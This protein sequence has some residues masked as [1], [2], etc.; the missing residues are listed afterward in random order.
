MQACGTSLVSQSTV[1]ASLSAFL[2][3][4]LGARSMM[5]RTVCYRMP[6]A[7]LLGFESKPRLVADRPEIRTMTTSRLMVDLFTKRNRTAM[8]K[9]KRPTS[10]V[11][12]RM[13]GF[14]QRVCV[15]EV[16]RWLDAQVQVDTRAS[17]GAPEIGTRM[18]E[19]Q[20]A[21]GMVLATDVT[22]AIN[23]PPFAR[24]MMD[25]FA[26]IA[27]DVQGAAAYSQLVLKI[28]GRARVGRQPT[29]VVR[30]GSTVQVATGAPL[31]SGADAVIPV[32]HVELNSD[33]TISA[34]GSVAP[35]QHVGAVGEDIAANSV[36]LKQGRKL[37]PQDVGLLASIGVAKVEVQQQPR[38][39][40]IVSGNELLPPGSLPEKF[41]IVDSNSPML[42][43]LVAR[44]GGQP[45]YDGI[46]PD[47]PDEIRQAME[48]DADVILVSGGSSVGEEDYAPR[49]VDQYGEL[50]IHGI[51]MRPSSPTGM[52]Y[53]DEKLVI[54]LPGNPV[55]CLCAY[56]FFAGRAIRTLAGLNPDWPYRTKRL[57]LKRKLIS[58]IGRLD[59]ARVQ[60]DG[61]QVEP[62]AIGRAS[63]LSSTTR[64]DGFVIIPDDSEGF[65]EGTEVDVLLYD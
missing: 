1:G 20:T 14:S 62:L 46:I 30:P 27:A 59:Y 54:L 58:A 7:L 64:A 13:K 45:I 51:A 53:F 56:D 4:F 22:S 48:R 25:G 65:A 3:A 23:V 57:R 6:A 40:L 39:R 15:D 44:D 49:I 34:I 29:A 10:P 9:D 18:V 35:G 12:V 38:V 2:N 36:V 60:L 47:D 55:S 8:S 41:Q 37:R 26:V 16:L 11:D 32:E 28:D 63:V 61:D 21:S 31:P 42:Q 43:S 33:Q 52:G 19:A 50:A 5:R 17:K 24:C